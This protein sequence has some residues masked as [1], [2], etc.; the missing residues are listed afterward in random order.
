MKLEGRYFGRG[1]WGEWGREAITRVEICSRGQNMW[2]PPVVPHEFYRV[3]RTAENKDWCAVN[4]W[5]LS[6]RVRPI[7]VLVD[8]T[9]RV[10]CVLVLIAYLAITKKK[11]RNFLNEKWNE[12]MASCSF[13]SCDARSCGRK[14]TTA[15]R[16]AFF[17]GR[18]PVDQQSG[19]LASPVRET[20]AIPREE[21][22]EVFWI[23][24]VFPTSSFFSAT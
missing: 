19:A 21:K 7:C 12:N 9:A 6:E 3:R 24:C 1:E 15:A 13:S 22:V 17:G 11:I 18:A 16:Y 20:E 5:P 23:S 4:L 2:L 10:R 8:D 14:K